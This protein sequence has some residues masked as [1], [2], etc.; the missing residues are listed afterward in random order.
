MTL[1][2]KLLFRIHLFPRNSRWTKNKAVQAE[3]ADR[4]MQ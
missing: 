2:E 3:L 4:L 1:M